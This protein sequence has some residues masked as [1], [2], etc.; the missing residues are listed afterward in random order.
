MS[1]QVAMDLLEKYNSKC[2]DLLDAQLQIEQ[3]KEQV[4]EL[5]EQK[6]RAETIAMLWK[7]TAKIHED[8]LNRAGR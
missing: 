2:Q 1:E 5:K 6:Q 4:R 8:T 3:L 7:N